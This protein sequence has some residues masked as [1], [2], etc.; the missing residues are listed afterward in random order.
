MKKYTKPEIDAL[1]LETLDVIALSND[2]RTTIE[3][4]AGLTGAAKGQIVNGTETIT[5]FDTSWQ[6]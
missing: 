2:S 4:A 3:Q 1:A 6:W 5:K